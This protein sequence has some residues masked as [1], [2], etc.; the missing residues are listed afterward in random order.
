MCDMFYNDLNRIIPVKNQGKLKWYEERHSTR[1]RGRGTLTISPQ[2][3]TEEL[4]I[5][6]FSPGCSNQSGRQAGGFRW[7]NWPFRELLGTGRMLLA[8]SSHLD[9]PNDSLICFEVLFRTKCH[10][11]WYSRIDSRYYISERNDSKYFFRCL[12][13]NY[14]RPRPQ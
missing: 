11:A 7:K 10:G 14:C 1:D 4:G 9:I 13:Q 8:I 12:R 6:K 2:T 3:F 5:K